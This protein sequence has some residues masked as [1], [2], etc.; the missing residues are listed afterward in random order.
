MATKIGT[1]GSGGGGSGSTGATGPVGPTGPSGASGATGP[2]GASGTPG[3]GGG[4]AAPVLFDSTLATT[5]DAGDLVYTP[6]GFYLALDT[7][8][9]VDPD[10]YDPTLLP[11]LAGSTTFEF[12]DDL[13]YTRVSRRFQ[14]NADT[15][16]YALR[17]RLLDTYIHD[18]ISTDHLVISSTDPATSLTPVATGTFYGG[19][20][21][22]GEPST[23]NHREI[24]A[25][26]EGIITLTANTDYWLVLAD[27]IANDLNFVNAAAYNTLSGA[28]SLTADTRYSTATT[29]T[30]TTSTT[31][32]HQFGFDLLGVGAA[33]WQQLSSIQA[34]AYNPNNGGSFTWNAGLGYRYGEIVQHQQAIYYSTALGPNVN[35]APDAN[36]GTWSRLAWTLPEGGTTGQVLAKNSDDDGDYSWITP[37]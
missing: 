30:G 33:T 9:G 8:T 35:Q 37:A 17:V 22:G 28:M 10:T 21:E 16:I 3:G 20:Y 36:P 27:P 24:A 15:D 13:D 2:S 11:I 18:G 32:T 29:G 1:L 5:Y 34:L 31:D 23:G 19:Y 25:F 7:S 14:V 6:K 4:G 26:N 12:G